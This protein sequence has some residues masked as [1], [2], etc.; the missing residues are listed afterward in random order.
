V[1]TKEASEHQGG[2]E[3]RIQ[4]FDQMCDHMRCRCLITRIRC[5]C[6]ITARAPLLARQSLETF[7]FLA[8][9]CKWR[10]GSEA[11]ASARRMGAGEREAGEREAGER[12]AGPMKRN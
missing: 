8:P 3:A 4:H 11:P 12:E 5:R 9:N 10:A 1:N 2:K 6:L 7:E